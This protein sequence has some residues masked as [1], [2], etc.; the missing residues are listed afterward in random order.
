MGKKKCW[1]PDSGC[2][3]PDARC[4]RGK[5]KKYKEIRWLIVGI[6][7]FERGRKFRPNGIFRGV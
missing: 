4:W 7:L 5:G 2:R 6:P 1:M 3:M